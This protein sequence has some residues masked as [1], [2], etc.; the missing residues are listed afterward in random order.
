MWG[1]ANM[2]MLVLLC[3]L[4]ARLGST[5]VSYDYRA[6]KINGQRRILFSGGIHYPR[7]TPEVRTPDPPNK[8]EKPLKIFILD[9]TDTNYLVHVDL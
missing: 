8:N 5:N 3:F 9:D 6:I 1:G 7:S 4:S 2:F